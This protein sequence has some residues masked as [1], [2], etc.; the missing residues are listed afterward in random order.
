MSSWIGQKPHVLAIHPTVYYNTY[1]Y[2]QVS[3]A[4]ILK[5]TR[6]ETSHPRF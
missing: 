4:V 2:V 3:T 1:I 6:I 5:P